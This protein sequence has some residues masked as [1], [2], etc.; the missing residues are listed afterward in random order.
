MDDFIDGLNFYLS[1][2][3][4]EHGEKIGFDL[5][6]RMHHANKMSDK[7][8]DAKLFIRISLLLTTFINELYIYVTTSE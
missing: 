4:N 3:T 6:N 1:C 2:D 8:Y 7:E 5:R